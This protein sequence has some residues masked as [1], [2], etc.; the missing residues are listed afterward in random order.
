MKMITGILITVFMLTNTAK[1]RDV[2]PEDVASIDG[3]MHAIYDVISGPKGEKRDW[4]RFNALFIEGARLIPHGQN[5]TR[6]WSPEEYSKQVDTFF[7]ENGFFER[8]LGRT[9]ER[10]GDIVHV[11]SA[12]DSRSTPDGEVFARGI[13]SFQLVYQGN[14]WWIVTIFWQGEDKNTPIPEKYLNK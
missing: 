12:Y 4:D 10:F 11:M 1:A 2:K 6:V 8:E 7:F 3:I 14:R 9:E 5:G 13:N